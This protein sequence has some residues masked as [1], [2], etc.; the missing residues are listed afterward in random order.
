MCRKI[1]NK[2]SNLLVNTL[3]MSNHTFRTPVFSDKPNRS[4]SYPNMF[5]FSRSWP[6]LNMA[7]TKGVSPWWHSTSEGSPSCFGCHRCHD[8][9]MSWMPHAQIA[10]AQNG[11]GT[12]VTAMLWSKWSESQLWCIWIPV[13]S[14]FHGS[15]E[16]SEFKT[17]GRNRFSWSQVVVLVSDVFKWDQ[18]E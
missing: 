14:M 9:M 18:K 1:G 5:N 17:F 10:H 16:A 7:P 4:P 6:S 13:N 8:V 11:M 15:A 12:C 2:P 3:L